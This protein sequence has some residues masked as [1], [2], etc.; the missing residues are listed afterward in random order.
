VQVKPSVLG[1]QNQLVLSRKNLENRREVQHFRVP[2][3][4]SLKCE[5][6]HQEYSNF[7]EQGPHN[8]WSRGPIISTD[9][10]LGNT[11]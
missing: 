1:T 9:Y 7:S 8:T 3:L 4:H 10:I 6:M 5:D 2:G 11:I